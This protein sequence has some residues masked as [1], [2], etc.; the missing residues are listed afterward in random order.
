MKALAQWEEFSFESMNIQRFILTL[1]L[2][3]D[4]DGYFLGDLAGLYLIKTLSPS[5]DA[6]CAFSPPSVLKGT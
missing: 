6:Y 5:S 1:C 4:T 2:E 3:S